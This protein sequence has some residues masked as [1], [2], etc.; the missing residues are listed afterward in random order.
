MNKE[1]LGIL[2]LKL[3]LLKSPVLVIAATGIGVAFPALGW[4]FTLC[5]V[6]GASSLG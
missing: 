6:W 5:N 1:V 4:Y 2:T 3:A